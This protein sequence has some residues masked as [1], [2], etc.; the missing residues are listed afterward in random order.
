MNLALFDFDGMITTSD[1][2]TPF[3]RMSVRPARIRMAMVIL[4][5]VVIDLG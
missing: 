2:W 1:S 5:S 4:S 3:M